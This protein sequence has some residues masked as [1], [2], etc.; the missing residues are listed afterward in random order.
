MA[1][2]KMNRSEKKAYVLGKIVGSKQQK[3]KRS[4]RRRSYRR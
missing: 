2:M 4:A 1:Q 3:A